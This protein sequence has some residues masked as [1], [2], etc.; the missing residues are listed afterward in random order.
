MFR[1]G[2]LRCRNKFPNELLGHKGR[3][4][5]EEKFLLS[6]ILLLSPVSGLQG[7]PGLQESFPLGPLREVLGVGA[8]PVHCQVQDGQGT[9]GV[10]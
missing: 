9:Q 3:K 5:R 6:L 7:P 10:G 2:R 8:A 1:T 4:D